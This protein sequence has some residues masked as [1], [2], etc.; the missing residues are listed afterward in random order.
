[1]LNFTEL[2]YEMVIHKFDI[3][4]LVIASVKP[5]FQK[6]ALMLQS[7][8]YEW[9]AGDLQSMRTLLATLYKL[10]ML[11]FLH[12]ILFLFYGVCK[13]SGDDIIWICP[14]MVTNTF[15]K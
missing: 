11:L 9:F 10:T 1:M 15:C 3:Q 4:V 5:N 14:P 13:Q 8:I 6:Y 7:W 2:D 12:T